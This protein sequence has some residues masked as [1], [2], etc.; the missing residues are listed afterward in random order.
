ELLEKIGIL[1]NRQIVPGEKLKPYVASGI[2]LGTSWITARGFTEEETG[3][4]ADI[5]IKN[6]EN[7]TSIVLQNRSK[8]R[9]KKL[10]KISRRNDVWHE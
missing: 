6:L 8:N 10:L 2:R 9:L 3:F 4:I 1:T 7:S 5:I